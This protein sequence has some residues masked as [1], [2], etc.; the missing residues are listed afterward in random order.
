MFPPILPRDPLPSRVLVVVAH[1]DDEVIGIGGLLAFHGR[2]GDEVEVVHATRGGGG[3]PEA[4]HDDIEA[5]RQ[6]E[7]EEALATLGVGA[8]RDLG[9]E[10]GSLVA[11]R[12]ELVPVLEELFGSFGI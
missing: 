1:P 3:D 10:D 6:Q 11:R 12:N 7:V 8:P 2:R 4:R 5:L 9:F